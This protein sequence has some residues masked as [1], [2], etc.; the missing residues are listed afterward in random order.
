MQSVDCGDMSNS[1]YPSPPGGIS[2][3]D[4][5]RA[6]LRVSEVHFRLLVES[7]R[8]YA[9][10]MLDP[11]GRVLSWNARAERIKG[12]SASEILGR[13]FSVFYPTADARSGKCEM[14][15]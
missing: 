11:T 8:D 13:H 9:I 5:A 1:A 2:E 6:S 15:L 10:F 14:E 12:Y 7:V 3:L 4:D